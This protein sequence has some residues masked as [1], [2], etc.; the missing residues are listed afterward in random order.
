MKKVMF[1]PLA[2]VARL[3]GNRRKYGCSQ[4]WSDVNSAYNI[5]NYNLAYG[6]EESKLVIMCVPVD[7][8]SEFGINYWGYVQHDRFSPVKEA[9]EVE[10]RIRVGDGLTTDFTAT[11]FLGGDERGGMFPVDREFI[12]YLLGSLETADR[13]A[14]EIDSVGEVIQLS[15]RCA[16]AVA[17]FKKRIKAAG[18]KEVKQ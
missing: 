9:V 17:D 14:L 12:F 11:V 2:W 16:Q 4:V 15:P 1:A 5:R 18:V 6:G 10:V 7:P 13:I 3:L 8:A